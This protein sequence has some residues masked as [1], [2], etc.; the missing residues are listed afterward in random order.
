MFHIKKESAFE[1][2]PN[3]QGWRFCPI[4]G[5]K[6]DYYLNIPW[7][8]FY[9]KFAEAHIFSFMVFVFVGENTSN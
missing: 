1:M 2:A 6:G 9:E 7:I 4:C 5:K 3:L 8:E